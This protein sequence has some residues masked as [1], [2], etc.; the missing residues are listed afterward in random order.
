LLCSYPCVG[1]KKKGKK[2]HKEPP[3]CEKGKEK[4]GKAPTETR[5]LGVE[6]HEKSEI[7]RKLAR[8]RKRRRE[9][10]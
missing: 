2:G 5:H 9:K 10:G 8:E 3:S 4:K 1:R 6:A 7:N